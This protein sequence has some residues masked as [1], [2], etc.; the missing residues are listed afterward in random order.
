MKQSVGLAL[1][2]AVIVAAMI[3]ACGGGGS[4]PTTPTPV[5]TPAPA[6]APAPAPTPTPTP[7]PPPTTGPN[8]DRATITIG[9]SGTVS[10]ASVTIAPGGRVTFVNN[11]T[12]VHDMSSDPHP[13]HSECPAINDVGFLQA[14]QSKLTWNLNTVRT[15]SFHDHNQP[16]NAGLLGRII[17][18]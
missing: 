16:G 6:P 2:A 14:G 3:A 15:C 7:T 11:D 12:R 5:A 13:E 1:S 18:Q 9:T 17:I 4:S 8:P 10:P